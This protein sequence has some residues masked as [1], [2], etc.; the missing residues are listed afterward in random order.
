MG[1][2]DKL[3]GLLEGLPLRNFLIVAQVTRIGAGAW[4]RGLGGQDHGFVAEFITSCRV[5]E[6]V[7]IYWC[8]GTGATKIWLEGKQV[9]LLW[10]G[11]RSVC[12]FL[13]YFGRK[14]IHNQRTVHLPHVIEMIQSLKCLSVFEEGTFQYSRL[15]PLRFQAVLSLASQWNISLRNSIYRA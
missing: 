2:N 8:L 4:K 14:E 5:L 10:L 9:S 15:H 12:F 11:R 6:G 13:A 3:L 7:L 1:W